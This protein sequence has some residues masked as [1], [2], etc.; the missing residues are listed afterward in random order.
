MVRYVKDKS[1]VKDFLFCASL[2][3]TTAIGV[4]ELVKNVF[5][6]NDIDL[7][8]IGSVCADEAPSMLGNRPG[9]AALTKK[10][11]PYR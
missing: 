6:E 10:L 3:T 9:F 2:K 1:V 11:P 7:Q 4:F 5:R 8:M